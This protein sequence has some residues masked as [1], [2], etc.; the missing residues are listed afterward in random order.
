MM[1]RRKKMETMRRRKMG[2]MK[3]ARMRKRRTNNDTTS[4]RERQWFGTKPHWTVLFLFR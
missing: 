2:K 3:M 4:D 1:T